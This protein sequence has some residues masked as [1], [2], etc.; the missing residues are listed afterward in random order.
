[1]KWRQIKSEKPKEAA[2]P[3]LTPV[4]RKPGFDFSVTGLVYC[5]TMLLMGVAAING[6]ANLLFGIF[7]LMIGV[8]LVSGVICRMVLRRLSVTRVLPEYFVAGR[9]TTLLYQFKNNKKFWPSLSV[10]FSETQGT[11]AFTAQT[12]VY[13][14]HAAAQ[15]TA[16]VPAEVIPKRRGAHQLGAYQLSTSFPFGFIKRAIVRREP[17]IVLVCPAI[18]RVSKQLL[19][20]CRS[21][22]RADATVKPSPGGQDEFYGVKEHRPGDNPRWIYWRRSARAPGVLVSREMTR[23]APPKLLI[24]ADTFTSEAAELPERAAVEKALAMA[25][26]LG[27]QALD[28]GLAVGLCAW[29]GT[30]W[31]ILPTLQGKQQCRD[32]LGLLARLPSNHVTDATALLS[33]A[34]GW[35]KGGTT[36]VLFTPQPV[37]ISLGDRL[38][39]SLL[40]VP[41]LSMSAQTWFNFDNEVDFTQCVPLDTG[42]ASGLKHPRAKLEPLWATN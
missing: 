1:M 42:P 14:L 3:R 8:L 23:V 21:D 41:A 20:M 26:T 27:S 16:S 24:L 37:Q 30:E 31:A 22:Q 9:P 17:D 33:A 10:T 15:M 32:L 25:A 5:T 11:E 28:E 19:G 29:D 13:L 18:G 6:Q 36:A 34:S 35:I 38:R 39:A 4:Y 7:G 2:Q 40:V 12:R